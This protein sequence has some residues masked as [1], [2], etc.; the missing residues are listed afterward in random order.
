MKPPPDQSIASRLAFAGRAS[1]GSVPP[2]SATVPSRGSVTFV[3]GGLPPTVTRKANESKLLMLSPSLTL[4][5]F[6][7]QVTTRVTDCGAV[8]GSTLTVVLPLSK[9]LLAF[10]ASRTSLL[11]PE[12]VAIVHVTGV[13]ETGLPP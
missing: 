5:A 3:G 12:P 4:A 1:T 11:V 13:P 6:A 9:S 7:D 10:A 8:P 2:E